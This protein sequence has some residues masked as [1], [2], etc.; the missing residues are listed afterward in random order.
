[1]HVHTQSVLV[2][3]AS[4]GI[5][6]LSAR[7]LA[8]AGHAVH[9]RIRETAGRN[10][11]AEEALAEHAGAPPASTCDPSSSTSPTAAS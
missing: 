1:M 2:A 9:A 10:A 5:G 11:P 6:D 4:S 3:G 8:S 7:A